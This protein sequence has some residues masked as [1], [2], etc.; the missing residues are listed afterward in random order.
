MKIL[1]K[2][3]V[4]I[5]NK[6]E[7][8]YL[9]TTLK[10]L[11]QIYS[12]YIR[13]IIVI[14]NKSTDNSLQVARDHGCKIFQIKDFT[15][16]KA[17]NM[18]I[19]K[20]NSN[21]VLLLSPHAVPV[22]KSFFQNTLDYINKNSKTGGIRYINSIENY[23]RALENNFKVKEPLRF[24]LMAGCCLINKS[25]WEKIRFNEEL[26]FS[27]DKEWSLRVMGAGYEVADL[28]ESFFYFINRSRKSLINRF[29]NET[30][31]EYN[32]HRKTFPSRLHLM[33]SFVKA[34]FINNTRSF[35]KKIDL[36]Y[37]LLKAK[38]YIRKKLNKQEKSRF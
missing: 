11:N 36:E 7:A 18:G 9:E 19:E 23:K 35:F 5:R 12:E 24:G 13:E 21:Y 20:A 15:Y 22:G 14:D 1:D 38:F 17:I 28:N 30:F 32:L 37:Q 29:K 4:V 33:G 2:I 16:G 6:N 25:V 10:I 26:S 8:S 3:S 34:A 27:E 31:E